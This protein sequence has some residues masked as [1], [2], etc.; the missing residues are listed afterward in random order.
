M[1]VFDT[2][3]ISILQFG[4]GIEYDC[5]TERIARHAESDFFVTIV[6]FHEEVGG[7]YDYLA[8]AKKSAGVVRAYEKFKAILDNFSN[9]QVLPFGPDAADIFEDMRSRGVRIGTMDLRI[10]AITIANQMTLLSRNTIDY[11]KVPSLR[12]QDW[13]VSKPD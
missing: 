12:F 8:K 7:W 6:S 3:H 2:D 10:A 4:E 5:L 11:E 13:L 9:T 1:F